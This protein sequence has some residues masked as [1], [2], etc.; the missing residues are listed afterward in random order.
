MSFLK[1]DT[2]TLGFVQA[3]II[4]KKEKH[5]K[6]KQEYKRKNIIIFMPVN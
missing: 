3:F 1:A 4:A 5:C 2:L 6:Q